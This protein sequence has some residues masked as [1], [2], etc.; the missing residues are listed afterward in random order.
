MQYLFNT[1]ELHKM[2]TLM[3]GGWYTT[4]VT[5]MTIQILVIQHHSNKKRER[6]LEGG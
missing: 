6:E 1:M 4:M 5:R 3:A 2:N